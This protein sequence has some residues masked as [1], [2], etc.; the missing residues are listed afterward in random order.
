MKL[1]IVINNAYEQLK[2][3][4]IK[5]ALLDSELLMSNVIN[6][7][8]EHIILN[9]NNDISK[10]DFDNYQ[11]MINQRSQGKPIAHLMSSKFFWKY[12]FFV[13]KHDLTSSFTV[14]NSLPCK[15]VSKALL[16]IVGSTESAF[17]FF[18]K[19]TP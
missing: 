6:K 12:E 14:L 2:S 1:E 9:L 15:T 13:N 4:N 11:N 3:N 10:K 7:S 5:S 8:R 19:E 18:F 16:I 17:G